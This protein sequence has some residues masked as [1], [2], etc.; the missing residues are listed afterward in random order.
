VIQRFSFQLSGS[1]PA[2]GICQDDT[3][4]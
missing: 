3:A 1:Q 4:E 2:T